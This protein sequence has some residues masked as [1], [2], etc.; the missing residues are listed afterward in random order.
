MRNDDRHPDDR[1]VAVVRVGDRSRRSPRPHPTGGW[2]R[3]CSDLWSRAG[4]SAPGASRRRDGESL[5]LVPR[6]LIVNVASGAFA[7][8]VSTMFATSTRS[9]AEGLGHR[10]GRP[11]G[12]QPG[13]REIEG[14]GRLAGVHHREEIV[15]ALV[16]RDV[17]RPADVERVRI[18][19]DARPT[20]V[21]VRADR[22]S[23]RRRPIARTATLAPCRRARCEIIVR[24][25]VTIGGSRRRCCAAVAARDGAAGFV[26]PSG[27]MMSIG[28]TARR[29][30]CTAHRRCAR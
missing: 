17:D 2:S 14:V 19:E 7:S 20:H 6:T 5:V 15:F 12:W 13:E 30:C 11:P 27:R 26:V 29:R 16:R 10:R 4:R 25:G 24:C 9:R 23:D 8:G 21:E 22:S 18:D 3:R 1:C 28:R